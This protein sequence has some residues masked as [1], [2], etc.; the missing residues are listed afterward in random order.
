MHGYKILNYNDIQYYSILHQVYFWKSIIYSK[1]MTERTCAARGHFCLSY[2]D[3]FLIRR[4]VGLVLT[5]FLF[6]R[7]Q[8]G[9]RDTSFATERER[10]RE[11]WSVFCK[12]SSLFL[13]LYSQYDKACVGLSTD[14]N[15]PKP[16]GSQEVGREPRGFGESWGD[17]SF[18]S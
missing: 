11:R 12:N 13:H 1:S 15:N 18:Y 5:C 10:E 6:A 8:C 16:R 9:P 4:F 7:S 2:G 14:L 3:V 17:S